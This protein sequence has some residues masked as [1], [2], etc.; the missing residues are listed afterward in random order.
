MLRG[1]NQRL[2]AQVRR[3]EVEMEEILRE[4]GVL[5]A[6]QA[7]REAVAAVASDGGS[8]DASF[9]LAEPWSEEDHGLGL[10]ASRRP[11]RTSAGSPA[12]TGGS[13][14][15]SSHVRPLPM[16]SL[17]PAASTLSATI[18]TP[19]RNHSRSP[20][21]RRLSPGLSR[22]DLIASLDDSRA[23]HRSPVR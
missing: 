23:H 8:L 18:S 7:E 9:G 10:G 4:N 5:R 13:P 20:S 19:V 14:H 3:V 11:L 2:E 21:P 22:S 17:A 12:P 15:R 16:A 6:R 1:E